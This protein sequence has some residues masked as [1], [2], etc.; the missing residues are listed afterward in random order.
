MVASQTSRVLL[1]SS[2]ALLWVLPSPSRAAAVQ[3]ASAPAAGKRQYTPA[4]FTRFAPRNALDMLRQVPGFSIREASEERGLGQA[5]ENVLIN[6]QRINNKSG[7][8]VDELTRIPIANVERIEIVE[9]A[10][11][12]IAGLTGQVANVVTKAQ[13]AGS[14]QFEWNPSFRAHYAEPEPLGGSISYTGRKGLVEYTFSLANNHGRG[15]YGGPITI[16]DANGL[17]TER[18]HEVYHSEFEQP[19]MLAKFGLDGPGSSMG[20]LSLMYGPYWNPVDIRD[21]RA[22]TDGDHRRR[23]TEDDLAGFQTEFNADYE[24]GLAGGR[25]KLI[26]LHKYD[27]EPLLTTQV[28]SFDSGAP[29]DGT[30]LDRDTRIGEAIGRAEYKWKSGKNDYQVSLERAF[31]WLDQRGRLLELTSAGDFQEVPFPNGTGRVE[32]VRYEALG[33]LSRPISA[34]L[35]LQ[36]AAGAETSRLARVDGDLPARRFF[37]PKGS[38]TLGWR[39]SQGWD[40]SLKLRRRVGQISFYD[41]LDQ[42]KLSQDRENAGN[43]DL[44]PPQ[45]WEVETEVSRDLGEWGKTRLRLWHNRVQDI[46]DVIPIGG[47]GQGVGNLPHATQTGIESVSTIQFDPLGWKGAKLDLTAGLERTSVRDPLTLTKRPISGTKDR[48]AYLTLRHDVPGTPY[49]WG[50]LAE[51]THFAKYYY[52]TEVF[53]SWEGP[54]WV[55]VF[56]EHKHVAGLTVRAEAFNLI[57]ATHLFD[58][59]VYSGRRT[60]APVSFIQRHDQLIGPIFSFSVKGTF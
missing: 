11:L 56:V 44:V 35:D 55:G 52:P 43:P 29:S 41:F 60:L 3:G 37:R 7:G 25:L 57:D 19:K 40:L 34:N 36:V 14:G 13:S 33:T 31:N 26:G 9:A 22:R 32:E 46:V 39:P 59:T 42:P 5:S 49:A 54:W 38:V 20:H 50:V 23:T 8:A 21:R 15:A 2:A 10:S 18:R 45:S 24:F 4:D 51:Y 30:K 47:T 53:R 27:H 28:L 6:G 48:W 58:R 16:L 12:G 1:L 17:V